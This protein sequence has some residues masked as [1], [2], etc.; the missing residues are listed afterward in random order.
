M[1]DNY[2]S[3]K[4]NGILKC[5]RPGEYDVTRNKIQHRISLPTRKSLFAFHNQSG[6]IP[7]DARF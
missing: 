5:A 2:Y 3:R 1:N 7:D 6:V 4:N